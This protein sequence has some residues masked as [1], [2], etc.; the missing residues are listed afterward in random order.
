[1]YKNFG[2]SSESLKMSQ[3]AL[4]PLTI[5]PPI[6]LLSLSSISVSQNPLSPLQTQVDGL[7]GSFTQQVTNWRSLAAMVAGG[8]TYRLG[9]VGVMGWSVGAPLGA[10]LVGWAQQAAPLRILSVAAGLGAEVTAFEMTN[11]SLS[12]LTGET[13]ANPNLWR[14]EGQGG[15][16]QGLLSSLVTFASLKGMGGLAQGENVVV[17]HLLQDTG[18]VL[19]HQVSGA[20]GIMERPQGTLAE[21]FL[22]AEVTNLQLSAGMV[23]AHSVAPGIQGLER[24]LD[25]S[26]RSTD[27][28]ARFPRPQI[29]GEETSPLQ[30]G[31]QPAV[32]A[33][34]VPSRSENRCGPF[35]L[36]MASA[37]DRPSVP[38][39]AEPRGED[40]A[41]GRKISGV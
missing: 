5:S 23:L 26:L 39:E 15:I 8:I 31:L 20:F 14:W 22:H 3:A 4:R 30:N 34:G 21:Q 1:M 40:Y 6:P 41:P 29:L 36:A 32:A 38:E 17:Q 12:S 9:R 2:G 37:S 25:L 28:G 18:M 27:G 24:G 16:R 10:P 35:V 33:A 19:G 11:R 7:V 13:H